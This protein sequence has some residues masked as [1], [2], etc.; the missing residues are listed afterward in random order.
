MELTTLGIILSA[1]VVAFGLLVA[2]AVIVVS[3]LIQ[4]ASLNSSLLN[5]KFV[6]AGSTNK[7]GQPPPMG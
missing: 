5:A 4:L 1:V 3:V 6:A 7:L 2:L